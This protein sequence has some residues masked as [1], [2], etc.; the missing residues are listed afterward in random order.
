M[1]PTSIQ[2]LLITLL[3]LLLS[4]SIAALFHR[5]KIIA[6]SVNTALLLV[7]SALSL[8]SMLAGYSS[9][10][11]GV[12]NLNAFSELFLFL[13]SLSL[14]LISLLAYGYSENFDTFSFF[15][16]LSFFGMFFISTASSLD[17]KSVV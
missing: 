1:Y 13:F 4:S 5:R 15:L 10:L 9:V 6:F 12:I 14:A 7:I 8:V 16:A 3:L 11:F 17:R 2:Y